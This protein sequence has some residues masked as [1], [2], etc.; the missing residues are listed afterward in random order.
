M[1]VRMRTGSMTSTL[2]L[3][4]EPGLP[5]CGQ[6][7]ARWGCGGGAALGIW[8]WYVR[9]ECGSR[10]GVANVAV[11]WRSLAQLNAVELGSGTR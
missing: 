4:P 1:R 7:V 11:V 6:R 10:Q 2:T 8:S 9:S 3:A 5:A